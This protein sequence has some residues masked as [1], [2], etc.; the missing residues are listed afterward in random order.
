MFFSCLFFGLWVSRWRVI[1]MYVCGN[2]SLCN[3]CSYSHGCRQWF[4]LILPLLL[5]LFHYGIYFTK[6]Y[7]IC[8]VWMSSFK[9]KAGKF[10]LCFSEKYVN[11]TMLVFSS[12]ST[13]NFKI[14]QTQPTKNPSTEITIPLVRQSFLREW[15]S[16]NTC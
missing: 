12:T 1:L 3:Y 4:S 5:S 6:T 11:D 10:V 13:C 2:F 7:I 9:W 8:G 15:N 14:W 16:F